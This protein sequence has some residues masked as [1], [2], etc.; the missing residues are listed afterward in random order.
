MPRQTISESLVLVPSNFVQRFEGLLVPLLQA[1]GVFPEEGGDVPGWLNRWLESPTGFFWGAFAKQPEIGGTYHVSPKS[2]KPAKEGGFLTRFRIGD[3]PAKLLSEEPLSGTLGVRV[4]G[5]FEGRAEVE[6]INEPLGLDSLLAPEFR[7]FHTADGVTGWVTSFAGTGAMKLVDIW[8]NEQMNTNFLVQL[9]ETISVRKDRFPLRSVLWGGGPDGGTNAYRLCCDCHNC[10]GDGKVECEK[11]DGTGRL[12]CNRC[13]GSG[14]IPCK[15]CGGSGEYH[16]GDYAADCNA[17]D[18][19]G[20]WDCLGCSG[21]GSISCFACHG[22]GDIECWVCK[23]TGSLRVRFDPETEHFFRKYKDEVTWLDADDVY[24]LSDG[25]DDSVALTGCWTDIQR[26]VKRQDQEEKAR[27]TRSDRI[28]RDGKTIDRCLDLVLRLS[29]AMVKP[30]EV[31]EPVPVSGKKGR[32]RVFYEFTARGDA[33]WIP[34]SKPK[35]PGTEEEPADRNESPGPLRP[36]THVSFEGVA[37][38]DG[39]PILYEGCD[40]TGRN[41]V[42]SFP[43]EVDRANLEGRRI[44]VKPDEIPPPEKREKERLG[45]WLEDR[46]A[47]IFRGLVDGVEEQRVAV[48]KFLNGGMSKFSV[49][50]DAIRQGLSDAPLLLLKG[51]PGTG[52]TTVIVEL[53]RQAVRQGK[54]VLLTSQ[55]HQAVDNVLE[56]LHRFR[57]SG[58]DRNVRMAVYSANENK[59]SGLGRRYMAGEQEEECR[60]IRECAEAAHARLEAECIRNR[61]IRTLLS[62]GAETAAVIRCRIGKRDSDLD[63]SEAKRDEDLDSISLRN[64]AELENEN[65][66]F[67]AFK[68]ENGRC[69]RTIKRSIESKAAKIHKLESDRDWFDRQAKGRSEKSAF[70]KNTRVG[71]FLREATDRTLRGIDRIAGTHLDPEKA[72]QAWHKTNESLDATREEKRQHEAEL[73]KQKK[74]FQGKE[75]VHKAACAS[76]EERKAAELESR[77]SACEEELSEIRNAAETDLAPFREMQ[78]GRI[79]SLAGNGADREREGLGEDSEPGD[80]RADIPR[81]DGEFADLDKRRT[82]ALD[83]ATELKASPKALSR[84]LNAQTNVFFATC[85]GMG[86]WR[87]LSD[88]TYEMRD[89]DAGGA[90]RTVFDI[91]IVD[92]AGHATFAETVVPMCSAKKAILIGDDRQLPPM[93]GEDLDCRRD[94]DERCSSCAVGADGRQCWF[95]YSMFQ[96]LWE[97]SRPKEEEELELSGPMEKVFKL[98]RLML[99]TQFR[100]HPDIADFISETFYEGKIKNGVSA[101]ERNFS[102][103]EFRSAVCLL[104]TS[105]QKNRF[106]KWNEHSCSNPLEAEYVGRVVE[107]LLAALDEGSVEGGPSDKPL[108]LAVITPYANQVDLLH[109]KLA[110]CFRNTDRIV[111]SAEDIASVDRFQGDERDVVI[112]SFVRSPDVNSGKRTPKLT[113]VHDLKRMN[114]AFS[115]A[116]RMLIL[117]GDIKALESSRG[118]ERG[119]DAFAR[120]RKHVD[121]RGRQILVWERRA[122]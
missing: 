85:V 94:M 48:R 8:P 60:E 103:G 82:F 96:Y 54:R 20:L 122:R 64:D 37:V 59:L 86:S 17:C 24:L 13:G 40:E 111:F 49:Q 46:G 108:S 12:T 97:L 33:P 74:E 80:W 34:S 4:T 50:V 68:K 73:A 26:E 109:K 93:L 62:E 84:F 57:E 66:T 31:R 72:R 88:G 79:S 71:R 115:R 69:Q 35:N 76:I 15:K 91:A 6:L 56:R 67:G 28:I 101:E 102:F 104:S 11:C 70:A 30:F 112:A 44:L 114:V 25:D 99:D 38:P 39:K 83:W 19:T 5:I 36:G 117:V 58:E 55:T 92:E 1:R 77:R 89:D 45:V 41:L 120:F 118:N 18:G 121:K 100:M 81:L 98:P 22:E 51:P 14:T 63:A 87:A 27:R 2:S 10:Q 23:G 106:E 90:G 53:I 119:R 43:F 116:R 110:G 3:C 78:Q 47:P 65:E 52:K 21:S 42:F 16:R 95:E 105:D 9:P 29:P 32:N 61:T 75:A 107:D 7:V 113:F